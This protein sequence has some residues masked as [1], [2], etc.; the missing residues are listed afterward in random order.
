MDFWNVM[1]VILFIG[2]VIGII[3]VLMGEVIY[4]VRGL[5]IK[6]VICFLVGSLVMLLLVVAIV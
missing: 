1:G 3:I 5:W 2:V 6:F 4:W